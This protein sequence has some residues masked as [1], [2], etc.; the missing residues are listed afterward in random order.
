MDVEVFKVFLDIVLQRRGA[1]HRNFLLV[2]V[3]E[4]FKVFSQDRGNFVVEQI[5]KVFGPRQ[6]TP[7]FRGAEP[8]N[9]CLAWVWWCRPTT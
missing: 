9:P 4:I 3:E 2:H 8:R 5:I 7:A 1:D 6:D